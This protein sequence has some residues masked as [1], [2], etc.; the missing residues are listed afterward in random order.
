MKTVFAAILVALVLEA[1]CAQTSSFTNPPSISAHPITE[2][3]FDQSVTD[4]YRNLEDM[5]DSLVRQWYVDQSQYA[6]HVLASISGKEELKSK[7]EEITNRQ[8]FYLNNVNILENG[9]YFYLKKLK[10]EKKYRLFYREAY[11]AE[12][13]LLYDPNEFQPNSGNDYSINYLKPSWEGDY[14]LVSLSHSGKEMS[15]MII[16]DVKHLKVLEQVIDKAWPESFLGV[17][18]LPDSSGF[19]YLQF[20]IT[21]IK[22]SEFK[23]NTRSV[24]YKLG[25]NPNTVKVLLSTKTHPS[26]HLDANDYPIVTLKSQHDPY[27]VAYVASVKN[28]WDAYYIPVESITD[29]EFIWKLFYSKEDMVYTNTGGFQDDSFV[30]ISALNASNLNI[31]KASVSQP[32][33]GSPEIL[34]S[35]KSDEVIDAFVITS[36]G[37]FFTTV[38][39]GVE[40]S[41]YHSES[42]DDVKIE[43]PKKSGSIRLSNQGSHLNELW[44]S[45]SGWVS[46]NERY[47][48]DFKSNKFELAELTPSAEFKEFE[49]FIVEELQIPSHDGVLVP[50]SIIYSS[51]INFDGNNPALFYGYGA[52]GDALNPFFS[53][54]FLTWV[55]EGGV[56]CV[57]H[58]RGGGEKGDEWHKAGFKSTK[59]N[60]WKDLIASVEYLIEK[61]FTSPE[62][63]VI[64]SSSAGG[65]MIGRAMTERPELFAATIV[66]AGVL[67]PLRRESFSGSSN[68]RE[69]GTVTDSIEFKGLL[70]M[71][72]YMHLNKGVS[73]PAGLYISGM[74]DAR[75]PPWMTGKFVAKLQDFNGSKNPILYKVENDA[76]HSTSA[77]FD[78]VY[79]KWANMFAFGL[80]QAGHSKYVSKQN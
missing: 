66:D 46:D 8:D 21:D 60:T 71:D 42:P 67:N 11:G 7:M 9:K 52:Y 33:F 47:L 75:I 62:H 53:P 13:H 29:S 5:E 39:N 4:D 38:K 74:N 3:Y 40:S 36:E 48:Y 49:N 32:N 72:P 63:T 17:S 31:S 24:L 76:G 28:F 18:W 2:N 68:F 10:G 26:L 23:K 65:I 56:L 27:F 30:Y 14:V 70:A 43:L 73:Y 37:L 44:V 19:I 51:N 59:M 20:P 35:E 41:L 25:D 6:D 15:E 61:K 80:W 79:A 54:L 77:S 12:E 1:C 78:D 50:V 58:V 64:Y 16:V 22:N 55:E 45:L 34:V 69:Y 57:P